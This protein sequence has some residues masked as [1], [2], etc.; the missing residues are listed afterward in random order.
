MKRKH[1]SLR[2]KMIMSGETFEILVGE[3]VSRV[4]KSV[5]KYNYRFYS[6]RIKRGTEC[7]ILLIT[8]A[9][10]YCIECKNYTR[11]IK[12]TAKAVKWNFISKGN[13]AETDNPVLNNMRHI[14]TI[15]GLLYSCGNADIEIENIVCVPNRC[16]IVT[17]C[18]EVMTLTELVV[19]ITT[20]AYFNDKYNVEQ[21]SS[22]IDFIRY[23]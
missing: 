2:D 5:I 18:K 23:S 1:V 14:R 20:D 17:D 4:T 10:I 3:T 19:K 21:L 16:E 11:R 7:D 9:K 13:L 22:M 12:G 15:K 6:P 8:P